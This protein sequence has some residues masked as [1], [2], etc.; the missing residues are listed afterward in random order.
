MDS[1]KIER[2]E[3][4]V[5]TPPK[6]KQNLILNIIVKIL[7]FAFIMSDVFKDNILYMFP[8]TISG[9][10]ILLSGMLL[11]CV[12]MIILWSCIECYI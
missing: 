7:S 2:R 8:N 12:I 11:Q 6:F 1:E 10:D 3:T 9:G 4:L 5:D